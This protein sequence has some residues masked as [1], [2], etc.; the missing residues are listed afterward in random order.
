MK[1]NQTKSNQIKLNKIKL[2]NS[3]CCLLPSMNFLAVNFKA[4]SNNNTGTEILKTVH[5]SSAF[6]GHTENTVCK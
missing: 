6:K 1:L 5:H 2:N 3:I 4:S